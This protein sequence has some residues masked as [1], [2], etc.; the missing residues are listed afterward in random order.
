MHFAISSLKLFDTQN[1]PFSEADGKKDC[2]FHY[3]Q[4]TYKINNGW[5]E[6]TDFFRLKKAVLLFKMISLAEQVTRINICPGEI[7]T[8]PA[9][10]PCL[11]AADGVGASGARCFT[12]SL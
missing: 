1:V 9:L 4:D 3:M 5:G 10:P 2:S 8:V 12:C 11:P 7:S 6:R